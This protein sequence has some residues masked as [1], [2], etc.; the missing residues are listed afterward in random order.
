MNP[1][2]SSFLEIIPIDNS[3]IT[4]TVKSRCILLCFSHNVRETLL[5]FFILNY[6]MDA[7]ITF[8]TYAVRD[9]DFASFHD[10][11]IGF[12]NCSDNVVLFSCH[13]LLLYDNGIKVTCWEQDH[14]L[15]KMS[16][17]LKLFWRIN[18][19]LSFVCYINH[20]SITMILAWTSIIQL[21]AK[22][23]NS[24]KQQLCSFWIVNKLRRFQFHVIY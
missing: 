20:L 6:F 4:K 7:V 2:F 19:M 3:P 11:A 13:F 17:L 16:S 22:Q 18:N 5:F 9:I 1:W 15:R 21:C 10:F 23:A 8:P 14:F 24:S 12:W